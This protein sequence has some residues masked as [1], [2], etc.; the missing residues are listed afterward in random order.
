MNDSKSFLL[1][2]IFMG[3][4]IGLVANI[5]MAVLRHYGYDVVISHEIQGYLNTV[6]LGAIMAWRSRPTKKLH[7]KKPVKN[8][9]NGLIYHDLSEKTK[10]VITHDNLGGGAG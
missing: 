8:E 2:K 9:F 10:N 7:V 4:L 5:V 3:G 1:S 6:I